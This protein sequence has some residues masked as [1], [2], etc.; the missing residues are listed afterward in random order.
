MCGLV[1]IC[2]FPLLCSPVKNQPSFGMGWVDLETV[3]VVPSTSE[4][5]YNYTT[6]VSFNAFFTALAWG[7][8][9]RKPFAAGRAA[10]HLFNPL[11][12]SIPWLKR[13]DPSHFFTVPRGFPLLDLGGIGGKS[14]IVAVGKGRTSSP[15]QR[16]M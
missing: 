4:Y 2:V 6:V 14:H 5:L 12:C 16:F 3:V 15:L 1:N 8:G 13:K 9:G 7:G 11:D 10:A